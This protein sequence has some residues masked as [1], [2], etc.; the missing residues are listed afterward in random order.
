MYIT[1]FVVIAEDLNATANPTITQIV[2]DKPEDTSSNHLYVML[3]AVM[4]GLT[5]L[6][7]VFIAL[8]FCKQRSPALDNSG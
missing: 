8:C 4:G 1:I 3:G 5:L 7:G 2:P 6:T